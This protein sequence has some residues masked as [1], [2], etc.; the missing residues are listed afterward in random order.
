MIFFIYT[1]GW[2][3]TINASSEWAAEWHLPFF[4]YLTIGETVLAV[5]PILYLSFKVYNKFEDE[6]LK[7][8]WK[9]FIYGFCGLLI[10]LYGIFISNFLASF[11][12][13]VRLVMGGIGIISGII[14][15][16]L[17]YNGVG[18]QLEK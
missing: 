3:V 8:K 2:G 4:L 14:A 1:P 13:N 6:Q 10:F 15:G 12:I 18:R 17:M 5:I 16:Y 9:N 11:D 7:R